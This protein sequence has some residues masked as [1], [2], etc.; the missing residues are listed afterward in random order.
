MELIMKNIGFAK[1]GK[2]VKFRKNKYS[3]IGGDN[4]ASC[5]IRALANRNPDKTFYLIGRSDF[6]QLNEKE[7]HEIFPYN[8]VVDI[9]NG[10]KLRPGNYD[11]SYYRWIIDYFDEK[12][13]ELDTTVMMMGQVGTVTIPGKTR[14]VNDDDGKPAA[15]ID[16]TKGYATPIAVW[17]NEKKPNYVEIVNDPRYVMNQA[18]DMFHL[19]PLSLGQY[20]YTY[21]A[22]T[23]KSYEDQERIIR[24]VPSTYAGMETAFC[25]DYEYPETVSTDRK[26]DFM[27]VLNEGKPSRYKMLKE[28]VLDHNPDVEVYGKWSDAVEGDHR[29][30]GSLRIDELQTKLQDVK[31][32]F[33]IPIKKGWVTS[34]YIE[35]IHAGVIPFLHPTYDEQ[36]HLNIPKYLRPK[37]P[38]EL[39]ERIK[40]LSED[41]EKYRVVLEGIRKAILKPE[42]YDGSFL[43]KTIMTA[44]DSNYVEPN[45]NEFVIPE[46][47]QIGLESFF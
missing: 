24:E 40:A 1:L 38:Q 46:E 34:K 2:S 10:E 28:W 8:N 16:M 12:G 3:P 21:S 39:A 43:N 11:D 19:P 15:V 26:T 33:I 31:F 36:N 27:V 45:L 32:T 30:K 7:I 4:E 20:D 18:R 47:P 5:T 17:L 9:W 23:I 37:T 14:K 42:Y 44:L 25:L 29:F 41:P 13:I 22:N 6:A 35:M